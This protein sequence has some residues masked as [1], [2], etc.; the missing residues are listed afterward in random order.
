ME[1]LEDRRLLG[2]GIEIMQPVYTGVNVHGTIYVKPHFENSREE[3]EEVIKNNLDYINSEKNFGDRMNFDEL[4]HKIEALDCVDF[5][6]D[7]SAVPQNQHNVEMSG[8]DILPACNCL[9]Y[10]G[11]ISI[12]LNTME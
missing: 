5:I 9:L 3:I 7:L 12:E 11:E 4:F 8:M 6:Y 10:P 1:N 2:T